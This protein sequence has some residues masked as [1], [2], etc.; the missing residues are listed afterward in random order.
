MFSNNKKAKDQLDWL[1]E[2]EVAN[3]FKNDYG[4]VIRFA[5]KPKSVMITKSDS[6]WFLS[7][8]NYGVDKLS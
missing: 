2:D 7:S 5:N 1:Y 8:S 4:V 6:Y 3:V